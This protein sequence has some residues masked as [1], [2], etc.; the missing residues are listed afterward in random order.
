MLFL[1][2]THQLR[3]HMAHIGHPILGDTMYP[4]PD[5]FM[6]V[7]RLADEGKATTDVA[8]VT[9]EGGSFE[10]KDSAVAEVAEC[11]EA[12]TPAASSEDS[13]LELLEPLEGRIILTADDA[14]LTKVPRVHTAFPRLCLHALRLSFAHPV[15]KA[16]TTLTAL[17]TDSH[18]PP[19]LELPSSQRAS[20]ED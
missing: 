5:E 2:R 11:A 20:S 8:V 17:T 19:M 7:I 12:D 6:D 1:R 15:T 14:A 3:V 18:M 4:I 13:M 10:V 16:P 9:S